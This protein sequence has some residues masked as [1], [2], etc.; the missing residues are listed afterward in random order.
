L[1]IGIFDSGI[2]GLSVLYEL[3]A[4]LPDAEFIY[5]ADSKN[6]PYGEKSADEIITLTE[7]ALNFLYENG[8]DAVVL[9]CNTATAAAAKTLRARYPDR[10]IF[11]MEPA[12]NEA[13]K[14]IKDGKILATATPLTLG[15]EKYHDLLGRTGAVRRTVSLPLP[16]LVRLAEKNLFEEAD[17]HCLG[18][19]EYIKERLS[20]V[21]CPTDRIT[22]IVLGCTHF[23]Y[24]ADTFRALLPDRPIFNGVSGTASH[25]INTLGLENE[26]HRPTAPDVLSRTKVFIS[27]ENADE[28]ALKG[29][30]NCLDLLSK[31]TF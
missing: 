8:A 16:K 20:S 5:F 18:A 17:S 15:G 23:T 13:A 30:K 29:T 19:E 24:F 6:A 9:A 3:A 7:R 2:G 22:A 26:P 25:V 4:R 1:K 10:K 21:D 31:M 11:G 27:G 12:V 14:K 28:K